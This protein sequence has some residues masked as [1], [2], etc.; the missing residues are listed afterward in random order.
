MKEPTE[1]QLEAVKDILLILNKFIDD[2]QS[3]LFPFWEK[4][5][6]ICKENNLSLKD[7]DKFN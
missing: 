5:I 6:E 3:V 1:Q 2:L 7:K 4:I